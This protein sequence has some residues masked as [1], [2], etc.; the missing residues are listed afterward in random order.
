MKSQYTSSGKKI[1]I[2]GWLT[3]FYFAVIAKSK[4]IIVQSQVISLQ[5]NSDI[6]C[7]ASDTQANV[8]RHIRLTTESSVPAS[9]SEQ[10]RQL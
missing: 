5:R 7:M 10:W 4:N 8:S 6:L 9:F 1:I 2:V 3:S